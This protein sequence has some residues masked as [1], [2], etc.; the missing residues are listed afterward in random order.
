MIIHWIYFLLCILG[1]HAAKLH[2][3]ETK[4]GPI[5]EGEGGFINISLEDDD[6]DNPWHGARMEIISLTPTQVSVENETFFIS[7]EDI[8]SSRNISIKIHAL[9]FGHGKILIEVFGVTNNTNNTHHLDAFVKVR[10][11]R[12]E[13]IIDNIFLAG[14]F[15]FMTINNINMGCVMDMAIVKEVFRK[16]IGPIIGFCS[17]FL[18]MPLASYGFSIAFFDSTINR[19]GLFTLGCSPGGTGSNFWTLILGGD[20]NLSVVMTFTS[21][22]LALGMMPLWLF[23]LGRSFFDDIHIPYFNLF[24]TLLSLILP[25][26]VGILIRYF[27]PKWAKL[28]EKIV[29]PTTIIILIFFLTIGIYSNL[30]LLR[31]FNWQIVMAG[32]C[33]AW[34]GYIF[35]AL[36]AWFLC[37]ERNQIIAISIETAFQN[38]A[39]AFLVLKLSLPAPDADLASVSLVAQ[40]FVTAIPLWIAYIVMCMHERM[41]AS[42]DEKKKIKLTEEGEE[43]DDKKSADL[44]IS[45]PVRDDDEQVDMI[46]S[47]RDGEED[48]VWQR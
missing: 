14:I 7:E 33:V 15:I 43:M 44:W 29:R 5:I 16:P 42:P 2:V 13:R 4:I 3:Y 1:T 9:V 47:F 23:T 41:N 30:F 22:V 21:T 31:L 37:M 6:D 19:L 35:G 40:L 17:Q 18:F 8:T 45:I 28:A 10:I 36:A 48:V 27:K 11:T 12:R 24:T 34:G 25:V 20:L 38:P 26:G 39:I 46:K 32:V